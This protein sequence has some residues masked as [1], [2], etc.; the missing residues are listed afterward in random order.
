MIRQPSK[1][2]LVIAEEI[3]GHVNYGLTRQDIVHEWAEL[4]DEGNLPLIEAA[5]DLIDS[6]EAHQ[7]VPEPR[8]V[9]KLREILADYHAPPTETSRPPHSADSRQTA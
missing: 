2:S 6:A 3:L 9:R 4:L 7:G 5:N 8:Y 1:K